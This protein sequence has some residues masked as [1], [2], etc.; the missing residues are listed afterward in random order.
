LTLRGF[1]RGISTFPNKQTRS[2]RRCPNTSQAWRSGHRS[3][4]STPIFSPSADRAIKRPR[5]PNDI[6]GPGQLPLIVAAAEP[7]GTER[8]Y[9]GAR[10]GE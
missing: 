1:G 7:V 5:K 4:N 2:E 10:R 8:F 3:E 6:A 9:R